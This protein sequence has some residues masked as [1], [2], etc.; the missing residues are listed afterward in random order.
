MRL[1]LFA[2]LVIADRCA[3]QHCGDLSEFSALARCEF[4][5]PDRC[6]PLNE[7][8]CAGPGADCTMGI[9][10]S[11]PGNCAA[12]LLPLR[13]ACA[14]FLNYYGLFEHGAMFKSLIDSAAEQCAEAPAPQAG[15]VQHSS[16]QAAGK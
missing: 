13:A 6:V 10:S 14:D 16:A 5:A 7:A 8:C 11:C 3:A 9:P 15:E 4:I 1:A 2:C 12:A